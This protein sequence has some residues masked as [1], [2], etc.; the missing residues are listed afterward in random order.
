LLNDP[1]DICDR[2]S[3]RIRPLEG[4]DV[5]ILCPK[6]QMMRDHYAT[7]LRSKGIACRLQEEGWLE[8][9]SI[10]L[11]VHALALLSDPM[12]RHAAL[13]LAV[14]E[15][16]S[17][18]LQD[19][20]R[21]ALDGQDLNF[22]GRDRLLALQES[23][24]NLAVPHLVGEVIAALGLYDAVASWSDGAQQRANLLRLEAEANRFVASRSETLAAHGIFGRG[25]QSFLPW[26]RVRS[27]QDDK[28]PAPSHIEQ[29]AVELCTWH[30]SKGREWPV[31]VVAGLGA[32]MAVYFPSVEVEYG[33][34]DHLCSILEEA[35]V[36]FYPAF[37]APETLEAFSAPLRTKRHQEALRLLY[38]AMTRAREKLILEWP[39]KTSGWNYFD[40]FSDV[41]GASLVGTKMTLAGEDHEV[42]VADY[43]GIG[44]E[45]E[46]LEDDQVEASSGLGSL[47]LRLA[48]DASPSST[49]PDHRTASG[50]TKEAPIDAVEPEQV[51]YRGPLHVDVALRAVERGT[52]L[53]RCFEVLGATPQSLSNLPEVVGYGLSEE[54]LFELAN[55]A[56]TFETWLADK[57]GPAQL[58]HEYPLIYLDGNG[59]VVEGVID[60]LVETES[61]YWILDH[62]S[63]RVEDLAER[64]N[65][66]LGQLDCY[67]QG[68]DLLGTKPVVGIGVHWL[69]L[70]KC[71]LLKLP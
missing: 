41:A 43:S 48:M 64:F 26:V 29:G 8:S 18:S 70:G 23:S 28:Q 25:L 17:S 24:M 13:Y 68:V 7:A 14:T 27:E 69:S 54:D 1:P 44:A 15:L 56:E 53:H 19:A 67:R 37:D 50:G 36:D 21:D 63:D 33:N 12:D 35:S 60:L 2:D 22:A 45:L 34:F 58:H 57:F 52:V 47:R 32:Q 10:Q 40:T 49:T 6:N 38:V 55:A 42:A 59:T 30:S 9:R 65:I 3:G 66:Y 46:P 61:S 5:A 62:K 16:G 51:S 4:R 39:Q 31:V 11:A 20:L 71:S